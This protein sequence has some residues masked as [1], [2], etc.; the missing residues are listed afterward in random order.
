MD[1]KATA[2][3]RAPAPAGA[4]GALLEGLL[5]TTAST[6]PWSAAARLAPQRHPA[7][8]RRAPAWPGA[9]TTSRLLGG[10]AVILLA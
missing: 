1:A 7:S 9:R 4:E 3:L 10:A 6:A 8:V 5:T 2:G